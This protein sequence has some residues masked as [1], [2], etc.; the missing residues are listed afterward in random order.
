M[1]RAS[2]L[3]GKLRFPS[4]CFNGDEIACAAWAPAVG[5]R[6]AAHTR[7]ERV[8]RGKLIVG[9]DDS[10]WQRQLW[11]MRAQVLRNLEKALGPGVVT[12]LELRVA[13]PRRGPQ[14][15]SSSSPRAAAPNRQDDEAER[16]ED[17]GM[18]RVYRESR[19]RELA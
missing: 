19:K 10:M 17:P 18:R 2:R 7:A 8:V 6:I 1:D 3:L 9:V 16:I 13:P 5:S 12:D 4:E 15:A 11:T 14:P